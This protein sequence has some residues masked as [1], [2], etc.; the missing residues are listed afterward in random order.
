MIIYAYNYI[1]LTNI[2]DNVNKDVLDISL[3]D[4][5]KRKFFHSYFIEDINNIVFGKNESVDFPTQILGIL[6]IYQIC[7]S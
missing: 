6:F 4:F 1:T 5:I 7:D 3:F 2:T